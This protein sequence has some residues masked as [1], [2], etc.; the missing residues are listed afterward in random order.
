M[1]DAT[2]E[3]FVGGCQCGAVRYQIRASAVALFAC[4]CHEC[5]K[6]SG[7][8]F[9]MALWLRTESCDIAGELREWTR[10]TPQGR[11]MRCQF[12]PNCGSRVFH[13]SS[14]D[15]QL[16]SIKPGTLDDTSWLHPRTH[17]WR[18]SAQPW[19][20]FDSDCV[21]DGNPP[22]FQALSIQPDTTGVTKESGR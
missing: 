3:S 22:D 1:P 20:S 14:P 8:A 9:G 15:P 6:Q 10:H 21:F 4:H 18:S 7:S 19:V 16:I 2:P 13:R 17:I 11:Q 5:Q 12:C